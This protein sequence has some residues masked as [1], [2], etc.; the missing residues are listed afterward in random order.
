MH[1]NLYGAAVD[2]SNSENL[3][4][5]GWGVGVWISSDKGTTWTDRSADL[6]SPNVFAL[7]YDPENPGRLFASTFEEGTVYTDDG[8]RS[9]NE[10]GLYGALVNDLGFVAF[11]P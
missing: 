8:G 5:S 3:A 10:G 1:D 11:Q 7:A 2:P 6:P 4:V 9:W